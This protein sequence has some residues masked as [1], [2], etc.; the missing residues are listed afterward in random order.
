MCSRSANSR[1]LGGAL[2][3]DPDHRGAERVELGEAVAEGAALRRAAAGAGDV[4][5]AGGR[6]LARDAGPR[7]DVGDDR[8]TR[9]AA[10][11]STRRPASRAARGRAS[12]PWTRWSAAP[13]SSGT[14]RSRQG[15]AS[16]SPPSSAEVGAG[17]GGDLDVAADRADLLGQRG[18]LDVADE[19]QLSAR[20]GGRSCRSGWGRRR[21]GRAG[22]DPL[23][24]VLGE[25]APGDPGEE[26]VD[27]ASRAPRRRSGWRC[28]GGRGAGRRPGSRSPR[29]GRSGRRRGR[30]RRGARR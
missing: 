17:Q 16:R 11:R 29:P 19:L 9:A 10:P 28:P 6:G 2:G 24:V 20:A 23:P 22:E 21:G 27:A 25:A 30:G 18:E 4:V 3:A 26:D 12:D 14:G 8:P 1:L 7:V 15:T 5:P 13:S